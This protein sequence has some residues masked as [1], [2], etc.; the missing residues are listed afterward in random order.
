[1]AVQSAKDFSCPICFDIF[2][3]P[4]LLSC[5]H[6]FCKDCVQSWWADKPIPQCPVCTRRSSKTD[7]PCNLVLK[8]LCEAFLQELSLEDTAAA[9]SEDLCGLHSEK[10]KLFC[11]DHEQPVCIICRDSKTHTN[12]RFRPINEA[13]QD[14]KEE[15]RKVLKPLQEKVERLSQLKVDWDQTTEHINDQARHTEKRIKDEFKKL[16]DFLQK[17][18]EA[19][20]TVLREE[21]EQKSRMMKQRTEALSRE[22]ATLS[23]MIRSTEKELKTA[24]VSFLHNYKAAVG[25]VQRRPLVHDPQ[26]ASG[27]LID[28]AKHVGNLAFNIWNKMKDMVSYTP[29]ILDPNTAASHLFVSEDLTSVRWEEM[30]RQLPKNPER[31]DCFLTVLGSEGFNSGTHSWDVEVRTDANW[32]V[33]VIEESA[34]RKGN[35]QTGSWEIWFDNGKYRAYAPPCV[36]RTLSVKNQIR[37]IRVHLDW[38]R[39]KLS[40]FDLDTNT[41]IYTFSQTFTERM[42]PFINTPSTVPLRISPMKVI[43]QLNM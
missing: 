33:G 18:E 9:G 32:A 7:P 38:S 6:S 4:V 1:M 40:F 41:Q 19:R 39:G 23:E 5:S 10:L 29:V 22:I 37:R 26:L 14:Y 28:V 36:D 24:D 11:L 34:Q 17:E 43:T 27:V 8:N 2:K 25:R 21:E 20:L 13:A 15:L 30:Q 42:F 12:H 16:Q 31:F 35:I 3:N